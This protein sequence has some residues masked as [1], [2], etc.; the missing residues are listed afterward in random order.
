MNHNHKDIYR[1]TFSPGEALDFHGKLRDWLVQYWNL[2]DSEIVTVKEIGCDDNSCPVY[3]TII[4][5]YPPG[6]DNPRVLKLGKNKN[7][8]TK[9][10]IV[11]SVKKQF[12]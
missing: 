8:L 6:S 4:M 9:Q 7:L 11:F 12:G 2:S 3:E 1:K 10:D 5:A